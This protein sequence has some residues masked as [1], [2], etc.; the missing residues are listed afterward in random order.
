MMPIGWLPAAPNP[1][2]VD[3]QR[4]CKRESSAMTFLFLER[5]DFGVAYGW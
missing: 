3:D 5:G 4:L 1:K 2:K